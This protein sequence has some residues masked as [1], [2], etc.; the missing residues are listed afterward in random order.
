MARESLKPEPMRT[1]ASPRVSWPREVQPD[2]MSSRV[3]GATR[4]PRPVATRMTQEEMSS[5]AREV[6]F[7]N[8]RLMSRTR[9][10][11]HSLRGVASARFSSPANMSDMSKTLE[12]S[13]PLRAATSVSWSTSLNMPAMLVAEEVLVAPADQPARRLTEAWVR[14]RQPSNMWEKLSTWLT[15]QVPTPLRVV[16]LVSP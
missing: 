3:T 16:S 11:V 1:E 12:V 9:S 7:W 5:L 10:T 8:M 13:Q 4:L 14:V 15:F 2:S 6:S